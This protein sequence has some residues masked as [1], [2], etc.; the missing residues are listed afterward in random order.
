MGLSEEEVE[1]RLGVAE[2]VEARPA[3]RP[4]AP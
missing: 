1:V 4:L 3:R 2:D